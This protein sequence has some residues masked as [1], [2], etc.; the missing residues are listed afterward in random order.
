[1]TPAQLAALTKGEAALMG[2]KQPTPELS[3]VDDL[4]AFAA[5]TGR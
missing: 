3:D 4:A 2:E 1:M 5:T